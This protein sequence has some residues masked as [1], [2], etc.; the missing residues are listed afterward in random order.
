M[1]PSQE[2]FDLIIRKYC[3]LGSTAEVNYFNFCNDLDRA[4]DIFPNYVPKI[5]PEPP[6]YTRGV[7]PKQISPFFAQST[8][9]IDVIN[10][11]YL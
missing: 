10:N 5:A 6:V 9:G 1:P 4:E 2:I 8:E 7:P 3:D 11:R